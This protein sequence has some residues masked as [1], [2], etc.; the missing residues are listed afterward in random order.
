MTSLK[1]AGKY[2]DVGPFEEFGCESIA[3]AAGRDAGDE[4]IDR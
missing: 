1:A 2:V 3:Q 4:D